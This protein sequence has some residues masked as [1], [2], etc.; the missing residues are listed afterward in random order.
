LTPFVPWNPAAPGGCSVFARHRHTRR[1][2]SRDHPT[3]VARHAL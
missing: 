1:P 3:L 2:R